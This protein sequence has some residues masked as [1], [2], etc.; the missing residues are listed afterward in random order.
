[1]PIEQSKVTLFNRETFPANIQGLAI[2]YKSR[3]TQFRGGSALVKKVYDQQGNPWAFKWYAK[4]SGQPITQLR[5]YARQSDEDEKV[6]LQ[7]GVAESEIIDAHYFIA[8]SSRDQV[9]PTTPELYAFQPWSEGQTSRDTRLRDIIFKPGLRRSYANLL[10]NCADVFTQTGRYAD[11][12]GGT[13]INIAGKD[14]LDLRGILM[15]WMTT[16]I[17]IEGDEVKIIDAKTIDQD[18]GHLRLGFVKINRLAV[19]AFG[20]FLKAVDKIDALRK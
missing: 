7:S 6:H 17:M 14:I 15:P 11:L 1:M 8:S 16:N 13:R 10:L 2:D 18:I 4:L 12:I 20:K 3:N 5:E 9:V 19:L